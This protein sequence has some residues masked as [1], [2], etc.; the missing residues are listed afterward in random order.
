MA[1][2]TEDLDGY[3]VDHLNDFVRKGWD[4]WDSVTG[5]VEG[6]VSSSLLMRS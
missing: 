3:K 2:F 4:I 6:K 5:T 1:M